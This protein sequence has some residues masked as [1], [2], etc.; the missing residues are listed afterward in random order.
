MNLKL[1]GFI[2][3]NYNL[4]EPSNLLPKIGILGRGSNWSKRSDKG[5][6]V[7]RLRTKYSLKG[8][9]IIY[10]GVNYDQVGS[11][12]FFINNG[13]NNR[14]ILISS[15][16]QLVKANQSTKDTSVD[17]ILEVLDESKPLKLV[18][19]NS[20]Q[21]QKATSGLKAHQWVCSKQDV[22]FRNFISGKE[23]Y[24][25]LNEEKHNRVIKQFNYEN[26]TSTSKQQ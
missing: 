1:I 19:R 17:D 25:Y 15:T 7:S 13:N 9:E 26:K 11:T 16:N 5:S 20:L 4:C 12:I 22:T 14:F 8:H 2:R 18:V 3:R 6:K 23:S 24:P 10:M 21:T